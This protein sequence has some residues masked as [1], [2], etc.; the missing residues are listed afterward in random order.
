MSTERG[1]RH[2][3]KAPPDT[4]SYL[5]RSNYL[6]TSAKLVQ[7]RRPCVNVDPMRGLPLASGAGLSAALSAPAQLCRA[8]VLEGAREG[9]GATR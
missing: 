7:C 3:R 5:L 9:A 4:A 2:H 6:A 8:G 1:E